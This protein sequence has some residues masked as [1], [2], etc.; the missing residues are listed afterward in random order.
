MR[1]TKARGCD[2]KRYLGRLRCHLRDERMDNEVQPQKVSGRIHSKK[3]MIIFLVIIIV[4]VLIVASMYINSSKKSLPV[5]NPV[6][7]IGGIN[8]LSGTGMVAIVF[9]DGSLYH[10][11]IN[12][13]GTDQE[14][15]I[16]LQP[17]SNNELT[18]EAAEGLIDLIDC[19]HIS[20]EPFWFIQ[21]SD[22]NGYSL[23]TSEYATILD[24]IDASNYSD[25]DSSY[26]GGMLDQ[27]YYYIRIWN[28]S[29][30]TLISV[31]GTSGPDGFDT[32]FNAIENEID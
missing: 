16:I 23:K 9:D 14:S 24:A 3:I 1:S 10:C 32:L 28:G 13:G 21:I 27:S 8:G 20:H 18:L 5:A 2:R 29:S 26:Y 30:S 6:I 25:M 31:Y 12:R 7:A 4:I 19:E 11:N 22:S 17:A 15:D